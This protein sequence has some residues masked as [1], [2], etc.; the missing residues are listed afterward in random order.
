MHFVFVVH[1]A[2]AKGSVLSATR[3]Q[4][5][6]LAARGHD[7][8]LVSNAC[9]G[10]W[11]GV[12][13]IEIPSISSRA[14]QIA[15][16]I[17]VAVSRRL[18]GA[19]ARRLDMYRVLPQLLLPFSA[20]AAI[21][22]LCQKTVVDACIC[23]QHA[24]AFGLR[25]LKRRS[26]IPFILVSHGD[27]FDHPVDAFS[28]PTTAL[29]ARGAR[30]AYREALHVICVGRAL[31][32]RA[33]SCGARPEAVTVIPNGID[34]DEIAG[35]SH[36]SAGRQ[37]GCEIL[38]VGRLSVEKGVDVLIR[39]MAQLGGVPRRLRIVGSGPE[40]GRLEALSA[41]LGVRHQVEFVGAVPRQA[42]AAFYA[43]A[44][45]VVLPSLADAQPVVSLEAQVSGIPV[46]GSAVGGIPD[47]V[48]HGF[49]GLLV[50]PGEPSALAEAIRALDADPSLRARMASNALQK[51]RCYTWPSML[52]RFEAV[53]VAT[54]AVLGHRT[55]GRGENHGAE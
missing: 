48:E 24:S 6:H 42:L 3:R 46:I 4:A 17:L 7:V 14:L 55:P 22:R 5:E 16:R 53:M 33:I 44:D 10:D 51:A 38:Y 29:Y 37:A 12:R 39:S 35:M 31:R 20:A 45:L 13:I 21:E 43:T 47:V 30:L 54:A 40:L 52:E 19:L 49:N 25:R 41:E 50:P 28:R 23:C 9:P 27:I 34:V 36:P 18:P 2:T 8:T 11:A 15:D 26:G 1:N 32:E